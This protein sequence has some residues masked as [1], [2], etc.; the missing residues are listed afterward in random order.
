MNRKSKYLCQKFII[1]ERKKL[2]VIN[3]YIYTY[4]HKHVYIYIHR[5]I[6]IH[7]YTY[8]YVCVQKS[9]LKLNDRQHGLLEVG[10]Q[11]ILVGKTIGNFEECRTQF[12]TRHRHTHPQ[13]QNA[14][15]VTCEANLNLDFVEAV[16]KMQ[17]YVRGSIKTIKL[18][19]FQ[20]PEN[21]LWLG[22]RADSVH[23]EALYVV[24]F[25]S[26]V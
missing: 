11:M 15:L 17:I 18:I 12:T 1:S 22:Q 21:K 25:S 7:T 19:Q 13:L 4:T 8:I 20:K 26:T 14:A 24:S 16:K 9:F 23:N 10:K 5:H 6:Y 3:A 2:Y